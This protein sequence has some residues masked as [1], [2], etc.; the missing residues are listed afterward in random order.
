MKRRNLISSIVLLALAITILVNAGRLPFGSLW[1]PEAGF[2]PVIL[3]SLLA[4]LSLSLLVQAMKGK[5]EEAFLF[6][7]ASGRWDKIVLTVGGLLAFT[8]FVERLGYI[9]CSFLLV[10]FLLRVVEPQKWWLTIVVAFFSSLV[11]Y[12][13]FG[14]WL[15]TPLPKGIIGF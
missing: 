10:A 1:A 6:D 13:V 7:M 2:F 14:S 11:A 12:L 9:I 15:D 5:Q 8:L 4:I 3:G